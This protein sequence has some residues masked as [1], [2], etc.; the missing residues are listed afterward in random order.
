MG[1]SEKKILK[2]FPLSRITI[3]SNFFSGNYIGKQAPL[4]TIRSFTEGFGIVSYQNWE[5][6]RIR[7]DVSLE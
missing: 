6:N 2:G 4:G 3:D 1:I 5:I 7:E